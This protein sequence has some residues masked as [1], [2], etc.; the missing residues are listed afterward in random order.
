MCEKTR[1][2]WA[3]DLPIYIDYHD[4]EWGR[5]VHNDNR[6]FE[7]LIL[8]GMQAGLSWITV[9]KKREAFRQAFD[10]FDPGKV[11]GYDEEKIEELLKN[12]GIIRNRLKLNA[13]VTNAKAF[14]EVQKKYGSFDQFIWAYVNHTPI[15]N[16]PQS[17][18]D[19]PAKTPLSDQISKD[20]KK[21]GFKFVGS[22]IVYAFMQATGMVN[23]HV[24]DCFVYKQNT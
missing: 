15:Q 2:S 22:T 17:T 10:G 5:P 21:L 24:A 6:L 13:A 9:L 23:D 14:L 16:H 4:N 1:C 8:E 3:K 18:E 11:A 19:I 7:M 12:E 20:L